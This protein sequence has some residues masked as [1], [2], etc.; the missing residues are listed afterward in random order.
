[1]IYFDNAATTAP[2]KEAIEVALDMMQNY[3]ANPSSIHK[4]GFEVEKK[5][6]ES[7]KQICRAIKI[8][9]DELFFTSGGTEA[10]NIAIL[11]TAE[12][13]KRYGNHIIT[14]FMEHP[15][16]AACYKELESR[17]FEVS[18]ANTD[19]YGYID[20]EHLLSLVTKNTILMSTMFINNE[21]G[22]IQNI[23]EISTKIKAK[24][25]D[26]IYHVDAVQ[27]FGKHRLDMNGIDILTFSGHKIHAPKGVG[28]LYVKKGVKTNSLNF[29]GSQQY[30][31]RP[32]TE[33]TSGIVAMGLAA[34]TAFENLDENLNKVKE[35]R[36][37]IFKITEKL[38]RVYVNVDYENSSPYILNLS[39]E[40]VR[41]ET[42][43]YALESEGIFVST[44]TSCNSKNKNLHSILEL[45]DKE[46]A[47]TAVRFSFSSENTVQEA[48]ICVAALEKHVPMLRKYIRR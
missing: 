37:T 46:R 22:T 48:E 8:K 24:K 27:G 5:I 43:V 3:Y 38:E 2:S 14:N 28:G 16:T 30:G 18:Y 45:V 25:S 17:G 35:V 40:G 41:G 19:K 34:K 1:M 13:Y 10:N 7:K 42:L 26:L 33:N 20:I 47:E 11:G 44:G 36:D 4:F 21:L 6:N 9:E 15:S 32:G 23:A 12:A 29:G 31:L 39:F